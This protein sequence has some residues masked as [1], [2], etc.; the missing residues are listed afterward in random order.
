M[1]PAFRA[2]SA[3]V[4]GSFYAAYRFR[5]YA[6]DMRLG[7]DVILVWRP[8]ISVVS[9]KLRKAIHNSTQLGRHS[10]ILRSPKATIGGRCSP[11]DENIGVWRTPAGSTPRHGQRLRLPANLKKKWEISAAPA[12][13]HKRRPL[14]RSC[15]QK[16]Y[17]R[18]K[19]TCYSARDSQAYHLEMLRNLSAQNSPRASLE[20]IPWYVVMCE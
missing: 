2:I 16:Q 5:L 20:A 10:N 14:C 7:Q 1:P 6:A 12:A 13:L 15:V 3:S 8:N 11:Q 18:E 17:V 4:C 19:G 9:T